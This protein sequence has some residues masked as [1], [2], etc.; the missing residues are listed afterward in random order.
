MGEAQK[1]LAQA[2]ESEPTEA[3]RER[4]DYLAIWIEDSVPNS[5]A[6]RV[7]ASANQFLRRYPASPLVSDV[8]MKLAET[9]YR[10]QDFPNAQTQFQVL[11]QENPRAG[12][13]EKALFFAA[14]SAMQSMGKH[15]LDRALALLDEVVKKNGELKWAGA[16]RTGDDRAQINNCQVRHDSLR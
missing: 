7:I 3:A 8:R 6:A 16:Q 4:A 15:S 1:N 14:K 10:Q 13:T 9:Y 5:D 11:A 12:F 2:T